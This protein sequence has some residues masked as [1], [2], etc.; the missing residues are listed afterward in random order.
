MVPATT[1][2]IGFS[3]E[4]IWPMGQI[5]L[6]V[7]IGDTEHSTST[8][9]N[10]VV[11]DEDQLSTKHQLAVKGLSE[12]KASESN[13]RHIQVKDIIK[14][15]KDYLKT[16][17]S[18]GMDI[19]YYLVRKYCKMRQYIAITD[20]ILSDIITNG[21]QA[22]T[23]HACH[24]IQPSAPKTSNIV[25]N[26]RRNNEKALNILLSAIPDRHL[27]SFHDAQDAQ[28][29][30]AAIKARFGA[31]EEL[32]SAYDRFQNIISM[33]ECNE[34]LK[35]SFEDANVKISSVS[36]PTC[37]IGANNGIRGHPGIDELDFDDSYNNLKYKVLSDILPHNS[38]VPQIAHLRYSAD[39]ATKHVTP[40]R[41]ND[42]LE[43]QTVY[44]SLLSSEKH[45]SERQLEIEF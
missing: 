12:C 16:Y 25:C 32:D 11:R 36:L 17:S 8:W 15:V 9:M 35:V 30:W 22:T 6:P 20:H 34:L 13:I 26:A 44:I 1:P 38:S 27:L 4:I 23:E 14:E 28:S 3:G 39:F 29:L 21:D 18:P 33:L 45:R 2:L 7:K 41:G 19:S 37:G 42:T 43:I 5:L 40:L 24:L 10:F 31:R